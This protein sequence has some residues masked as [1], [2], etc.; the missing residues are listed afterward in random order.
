[1]PEKYMPSG[2]E[3]ADAEGHM[4]DKQKQDSIWRRGVLEDY[5]YLASGEKDAYGYSES[6]VN[7]KPVIVAQDNL[8]EGEIISLEEALNRID[9]EIEAVKAEADK[10][11]NAV[12]TEERV[13]IGH[14]EELKHR[15][16]QDLY[17]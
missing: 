7:G 6:L 2:E 15:I 11:I 16:E 10:K 1:M 14:L 9:R 4:T 5:G 3:M 8:G 13:R 17:R 12:T